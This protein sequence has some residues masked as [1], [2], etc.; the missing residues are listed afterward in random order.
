MIWGV[1][2]GIPECTYIGDDGNVSCSRKRKILYAQE[3]RLQSRVV[4]ISGL[5]RS[6]CDE[7]NGHICTVGVQL[8]KPR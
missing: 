6:V 3:I 4:A 8:V 1:M 5:D 7:A 2:S